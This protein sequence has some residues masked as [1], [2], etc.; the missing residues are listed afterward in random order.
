MWREPWNYWVHVI[1]DT[2]L[3]KRPKFIAMCM[4]MCVPH[5]LDALINISWLS[6]PALSVIG[7]LQALISG[8]HLAV[9]A[10]FPLSEQKAT[11]FADSIVWKCHKMGQ[12]LC[13]V[14]GR[15][16]KVFSGM[17]FPR[18]LHFLPHQ[19]Q[20]SAPLSTAHRIQQ[21]PACY[22]WGNT[23]PNL[24]RMLCE[25]I[26]SECFPSEDLN[27]FVVHCKSFTHNMVVSYTAY[28]APKGSTLCI[29]RTLC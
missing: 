7:E 21:S 9:S 23:I 16:P 15:G 11:T 12:I 28:C 3:I 13:V 25:A 22:P 6:C 26:Q 17:H 5:G 29:T 10:L 18:T 1:A 27:S 2:V 24:I 8:E 20:T 14:V 4:T 19:K